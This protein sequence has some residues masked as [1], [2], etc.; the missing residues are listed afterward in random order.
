MRIGEDPT[1]ARA[2]GP[3]AVA[4]GDFGC[5]DWVGAPA[6]PNLPLVA[7]FGRPIGAIRRRCRLGPRRRG[8]QKY[9][10]AQNQEA[11]PAVTACQSGRYQP[12]V[13]LEQAINFSTT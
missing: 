5:T 8:G 13:L 9:Q 2:H 7:A 12:S 10:C 11:K 1:V 6:C 3:Y 4:Q